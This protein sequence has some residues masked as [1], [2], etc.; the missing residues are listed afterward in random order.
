MESVKSHL[1][2]YSNEDFINN[3]EKSLNQFDIE[4]PKDYKFITD[5]KKQNFDYY[6]NF[7]NKD[8]LKKWCDSL[9]KP[10]ENLMI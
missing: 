4:V 8:E 5:L 1:K 10:I 7:E 9:I 2:K 6:D 3:W